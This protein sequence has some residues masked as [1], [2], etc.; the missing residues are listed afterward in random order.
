VTGAP[1]ALLFDG[2][3]RDREQQKSLRKETRVQGFDV[4][5]AGF[6]R[7]LFAHSSFDPI[8]FTSE[9]AAAFTRSPPPWLA[10]HRH[11]MRCISAH[12]PSELARVER[13]VLLSVGPEMIQFAWL[14][15]RLQRPDWPI[16]AVLHSL[17][18]APRIRYFFTSAMLPLLG[19]HDAL[20]C[21]SRAAKR[22][23]ERTFLSVPAAA[24]ASASIPCELPVI[25]FG[26]DG[27]EIA[28]PA[29]EAARLAH[30][31]APASVV[32][33]Y[34]GRLAAD[35]GDLL[36]LLLAFSRLP[37][38]SDAVLL[39]AG[40]DTQLR[41]AP[42]LGSAAQ[43][44]G[45]GDR[46]RLLPDVSREAKVALL[47]AAD[48][49]VSP[50][51][52]TQESFGLTIAEAMAAGLP[53]VASDWGPHGELVEDGVTG[54]L[55]PTYLP[56]LTAPWHI[57]TLYSGIAHE[58]L[59]AMSTAVDVER[60]AGS[61]RL[62]LERPDLRR[63][64]GREARRRAAET[65]DWRAVIGRYDDLWREQLLRARSAPAAA[66]GAFACSSYQEVFA[67]YPTRALSADDLV[68][69]DGGLDPEVARKLPGVLAANPHFQAATFTRLIA[70]LE[71]A[72][73]ARIADLVQQVC[74][75]SGTP[76]GK[77]AGVE[78]HIG[79]LL[80]YGVLQLAESVS[81]AR[82]ASFAPPPRP[83]HPIFASDAPSAHRQGGAATR[84]E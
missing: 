23:L 20:V 8:Y 44:L 53:V 79:R 3:V 52:N 34:V 32:F 13:L 10:E 25:P 75:S 72:G 14:R 11:R 78:R 66:G 83:V 63:A 56:P 70:L 38:E 46:V 64:M 16:T 55:V 36:P 17:A 50:T 76:T 2:E 82:P 9:A 48:V 74:A 47:A 19:R 7:A 39:V 81:S 15:S 1:G 42:A 31:L 68:A 69:L 62:L 27:E 51:E 73:P 58:N 43:E 71:T 59:L 30:G 84:E 65:L 67:D 33:L 54:L 26:V 40:D 12:D 24:R 18:P 21:P 57:L 28:A 29:R 35:K 80:K 22:A 41:L 37:R 45:C 60:L 77:Q 61:L 4:F 5:L 49:F 6:T